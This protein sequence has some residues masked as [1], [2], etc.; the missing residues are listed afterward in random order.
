MYPEMG[1]SIS[2]SNLFHLLDPLPDMRQAV[3]LLDSVLNRFLSIF[4]DLIF[5]SRVDRGM[6]NLAA[7]PFGP[8]MRP[9]AFPQG[10]LD[11]VHLLRD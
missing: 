6:P 8:N 5:D 10:G 11:H 3:N 7:A 4:S 9:P 1:F 2:P